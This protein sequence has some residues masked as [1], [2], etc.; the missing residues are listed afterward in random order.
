MAEK[1]VQVPGLGNVAFP[2]TMSD[3]E[4]AGHIRDKLRYPRP[5]CASGKS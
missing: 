2:D 1:I 4:I 3:D 5:I